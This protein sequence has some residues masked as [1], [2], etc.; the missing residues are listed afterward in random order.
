MAGSIHFFRR[1]SNMRSDIHGGRRSGFTL[2]ELLVVIAIIGVLIGLLLP[3]V[4]K[5]RE[6]ANRAKCANN[7][8]QIGLAC[9]SFHD[10][11]NGFP[12]AMAWWDVGVNNPGHGNTGISSF[13]ILLPYLE[14]PALYQALYQ[15]IVISGNLE[16]GPGSAFSIPVSILACPSDSGIP[17]PATVTDPFGGSSAVTSY[18]PNYGSLSYLDGNSGPATYGWGGIT[19]GVVVDPAPWGAGPVQMSAIT[20]GTSNTIAY[21]EIS[22]F[23]PSWP[24]YASLASS[25]L[26]ASYPLSLVM[27]SQWSIDS[28]PRGTGYYP[29]NSNLPSP[30]PTDIMAGFYAILARGVTFGSCHTGGAN[31]V[32]CDG[33]VRFISNGVGDTPGLLPALCTRAGGEVVD[34]P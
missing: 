33:S 7:L 1:V 26:P 4:Q 15:Q 10:T 31:F 17:S 18:R 32:F 2:A 27:Q 9:Q 20:D 21:G 16:G 5:V 30:P 8:K 28:I 3:A 13:V 23:D 12:T 11:N 19:D 29:L 24:Q 25:F 6:A 34:I 22:N 14:Q